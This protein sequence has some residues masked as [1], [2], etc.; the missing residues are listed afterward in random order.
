MENLTLKDIID[1]GTSGMLL[2][3]LWQVWTR[4]NLITDIMIAERARSAMDR[5]A[6][7]QAVGARMPV[8]PDTQ[9][10]KPP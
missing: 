10:V 6:I 7:A 9:E 4:L 2:F 8:M 5:Q 1:L 3:F